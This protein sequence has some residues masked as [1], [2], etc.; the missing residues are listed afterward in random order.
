MLLQ[1]S[2]ILRIILKH[3]VPF[4]CLIATGKH[5][6]GAAAVAVEICCEMM[7]AQLFSLKGDENILNKS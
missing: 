4:V 3:I 7:T 1:Y 5:S 2:S 6:S